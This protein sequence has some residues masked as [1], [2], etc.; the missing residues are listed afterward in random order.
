MTSSTTQRLERDLARL[1]HDLECYRAATEAGLDAVDEV[2]GWLDRN[3]RAGLARALRRN[4][5]KILH[6][7]RDNALR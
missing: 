6:D 3:Q 4:P 1:R 2:I 5:K 7:L